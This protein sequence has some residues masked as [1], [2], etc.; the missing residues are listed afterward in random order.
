M[1]SLKHISSLLLALVIILAGPGAAVAQD[2]KVSPYEVE[3]L[4]YPELPDIDTPAAERV[5]FDNGL[6]VFLIE[7]HELPI[8]SAQ[9]RIGVGSVYV[10]AELVGLASITE[11]T[12]RTGGTASMSSDEINQALE[13]VGATVE[14]SIGETSGGAYMTTLKENLDTV[15]PI[16]ADV[17]MRPAFAEEKIELAKTQQSSAIARRNDNPQSVAFREF[18]QLLYG[19][20]SPYA[21]VP[22]YWTL[23]AIE[24]DDVEAFHDRFF[25]PNNTLLSI[26][27]DFETDEMVAKLREVFSTW[28]RA[29]NFEQ[30]PLPPKTGE[31]DYSVHFIPKSDVTQSTVLM[32]YPGEIRMNHPDYFPVIVMNQVLSGGFTSRLFQ[33]VRSDQ[34]LAYAVFGTYTAGYEQPGQFY[35]GV[36]TKSGTTVEAA[37]SVMHEI[38]RMRKAPP[39]DE[40]VELAKDG[41]LNA[42]V[43]NFD[44]RRE[45][46]QRLMT[47]EYYG[48]PRDFLQQVKSGVEDVAP[49]DVFR[50]SQKYLHPGSVDL[51]VLGNEAELD[52]PVDQLAPDGTVDTVDISI[53]SQPTSRQAKED[54]AQARA[55]DGREQLL[56]AAEAL[57]GVEAFEAID[58]IHIQSEQVAQSPMGEVTISVDALMADPDHLRLERTMPMGSIK[59]TLNGEASQMQTPRGTQAVPPSVRTQIQQQVWHNLHYLLAHAR[60]KDLVVKDLGLSQQGDE[61]LHELLIQPPNAADGFRLYLDPQSHRPQRL[62][63]TGRNMQGQQQEITQVFSDYRETGSVVLPYQVTTYQDDE[64]T[65]TTTHQE[66]VLNAD[67][68]D[69]AFA[70][71]D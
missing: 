26:W 29:E 27:G 11:T 63:F 35:A 12:M 67:L 45:I 44:T 5:E 53:R 25:H 3:D 71:E 70:I 61:E 41:Y 1:T 39:T 64:E 48:Y 16:F 7:D 36:M 30:P 10:P 31:M 58:N 18:A 38:D 47:Y 42:F 65:A 17:L 59:V 50:V 56:Q 54:L 37:R 32:G 66:I 43:F 14:T 9:A 52:T 13:N 33:N 4:T 49:A 57:G 6:T 68:P 20:E 2:I 21:R 60:D 28:E 40:E 23:E 55:P 34:G 22:Q 62:L 19:E 15:L 69:D 51:L 8:V 24:R 46:V